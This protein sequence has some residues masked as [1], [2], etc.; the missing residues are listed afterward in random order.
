MR[1]AIPRIKEFPDDGRIWRVDWF[2]GVERNPQVP[3]E[4]KIQLIISPVVGGATDYAASNA[5]NHEERRSIS[6]GVGQLPLVT[7]GSLWQNRHCLVASAG[8]VKTFDNLII[9]PKTVR[10]VKSDVSVD[11]QQ[12]IRKKY[13]Q[14][15]AGLAT[16]CVAIEWQGDPY[17]IIIPT[18]EIIR[19]Y[20]A[21]S[22]DLAKAIFAGDFRHDLGSIVN[23]DEC[24]FVVPER[25]CILRLRK[26]FADADAWI[27]GRVLNCQEAFDGAALVHDSMIK[28]AVQNK[29]R[30]YPEAAFPFIGATNLRV[31]TKAMRTP[32]EKSWRFIVFALEHCSGPFPFSAITCDRDNSNLRPEEGKDLPDDQKEPA[33]PVKQ[34]SGKD[35]TDGELQ[36]DDEPSNNVQSAVVT[37]PEER[38]GALA[39]ME[40]EKPE[41]EACH[42]FS[43]GIVRPLALPTD[44]LGTGD[45][46][47]SDNGVTPTSAEIKHIR[48]EAMPASFENFEAMV[49]HL[50]GLAGCQ[51]KI[52]TRTDAIA[53][54]PLTKPHK[55]W[56]WSY[57]DSGRQQRRAAVVADLIYN[58]RFYS[59][60][61]F[62]WRE[63]ESFKLAMVSL[64]GR[65]RMSDELV[66]LL[67]QS[68]ARQDG[69]WEKIKPLPFDID[70]ATLKHTWPSVEAYAGAV[71][72][73][74]LSLV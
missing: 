19:F 40:L 70:L 62:Q 20:Y 64:P 52:R 65:A 48:Q 5:V 41:K 9:S 1:K 73:K 35:V 74:M 13:H 29:P 17:G 56:Q 15:G 21:T 71:M 43:A 33:Y 49:N 44:V 11:G 53:F 22:S 60:I 61:E 39:C 2:G 32:D 45:G 42:Y 16:N 25:R 3:S 14:I 23:P 54:I 36:S 27:I 8:K 59:L 30:V 31:R 12:L 67:L 51:T 66:V 34:P 72:K 28:Q 26:E 50:N 6:I 38:F 63:G 4:P 68:L 24:Q 7:I 10:L 47:Y 46:T 18:T 57:L 55:A 69:R 58:H 37:L